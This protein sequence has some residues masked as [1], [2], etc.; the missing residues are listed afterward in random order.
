MALERKGRLSHC[1]L[2]KELAVLERL[3]PATQFAQT[4]EE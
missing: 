2:M 4:F 1:N 3:E